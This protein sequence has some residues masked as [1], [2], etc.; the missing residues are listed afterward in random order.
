MAR[1]SWRN[2]CYSAVRQNSFKLDLAIKNYKS[3]I[4]QL[5][6]LVQLFSFLFC[7]LVTD[8]RTLEYHFLTPIHTLWIKVQ[9]TYMT[10]KLII[11]LLLFGGYS[12]ALK[13]DFEHLKFFNQKQIKNKNIQVTQGP[14]PT[15]FSIL[16]DYPLMFTI[17]TSGCSL[18]QW[19][20]KSA[21]R[22]TSSPQDE[23][24]WST[25]PHKN[26][27]F[28]LRGTL[29]YLKWSAFYKSLETTALDH[30]VSYSY[31]SEGHVPKKK[32]SK[33]Q[34]LIEKIFREPQNKW[35]AL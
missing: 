27:Y 29:K 21:P 6:F 2:I 23:L 4:F 5:V 25:I 35:K 14:S 30:G 22:T 9:K 13:C 34:K 19:F 17:R 18:D 28:V 15:K 31:L 24:K 32:Y 10:M 11:N 16:F 12:C 8:L 7:Q 33:G 20:P 1:F 3:I 26:Q